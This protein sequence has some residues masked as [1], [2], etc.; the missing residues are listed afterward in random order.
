MGC[1]LPH[2]THI[3]L[4]ILVPFVGVL[5]VCANPLLF[6]LS[7]PLSSLSQVFAH[8]LSSSS[9]SF[10]TS[11]PF[12]QPVFTCPEGIPGRCEVYIM[13]QLSHIHSSMVFYFGPLDQTIDCPQTRTLHFHHL[14]RCSRQKCR[15][16]VLSSV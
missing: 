11:L 6:R 7:L 15:V 5:R 3:A 4:G 8:L 10:F 9:S 16:A 13:A 12:P 14:N 1:T 2:L